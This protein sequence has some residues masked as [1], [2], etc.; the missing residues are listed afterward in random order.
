[1]QLMLLENELY[2]NEIKEKLTARIKTFLTT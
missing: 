1:M 2:L